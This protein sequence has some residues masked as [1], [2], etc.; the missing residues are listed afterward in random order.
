MDPGEGV[1]FG[2]GGLRCRGLEFGVWGMGLGVW[3][4]VF[5]VWCLVCGGLGVVPRRNTADDD[6]QDFGVGV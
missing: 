6:W 5:G 4:L 3:C 1:G 2:V